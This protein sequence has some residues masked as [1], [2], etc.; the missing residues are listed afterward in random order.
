VITARPRLNASI[1]DGEYEAPFRRSG[2]MK[3]VAVTAGP[4]SELEQAEERLRRMSRPAKRVK[5]VIEGRGS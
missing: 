3:F 2:G 5:N 4:L 1:A